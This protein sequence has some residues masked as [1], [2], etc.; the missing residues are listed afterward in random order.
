MLIILTRAIWLN[1]KSE[2]SNKTSDST[3]TFA[4]TRESLAKLKLK[5]VRRGV[6]FSD[7]KHEERRLL[8]LTV[9][10]VQRVHSFLLAKLI[11]K[12]VEKLFTAM[13]SRVYRLIRTKGRFLA[14][15]LA[16][17]AQSWGNETAKFWA[18]DKGFVQFLT[19]TNLLSCKT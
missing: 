1:A 9:R 8:D 15:H 3:Q 19:V 17:I 2:K 4:L 7:L 16:Q 18:K 11:S 12:I 10:V 13:E 14:E 6:W 5:A